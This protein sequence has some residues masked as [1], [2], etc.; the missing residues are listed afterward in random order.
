LPSDEVFLIILIDHRAYTKKRFDGADED[1]D[2]CV[3]HGEAGAAARPIEKNLGGGRR[4]DAADTDSDS[5]LS[6]DEPSRGKRRSGGSLF[7][8]SPP[9]RCA[10][11]Q[12]EAV[13]LSES[14]SLF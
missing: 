6:L 7:S 2:G 12:R 8:R 4:F 13:S 9:D 14:F 5:A 11:Y 1:G 10:R 3:A